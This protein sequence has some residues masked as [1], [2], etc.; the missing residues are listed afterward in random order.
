MEDGKLNVYYLKERIL[1]EILNGKRHFVIWGL[2]EIAMELLAEL[3]AAGIFKKYFSG[4]VDDNP[5][6][7]DVEIFGLKVLAPEEINNLAVDTLVIASDDNK[8]HILKTFSKIE[9]RIPSVILGGTNHFAFKDNLFEEVLSSCLI[10]SKAGGYP[11]MLIHIY[12]SLV[13]LIRN[14]IEGAVAEFGVLQGGTIVFIAKV[15]S[16]LGRKCRIFG[17]D[18]FDGFP[19]RKSVMDLYSDAKCVF[20]DF[21][22]VQNYCQPHGIELIKGDICETHRQIQNVPLMFSFFDTDNYSPTRAAL[23]LCYEQTSTGGILAFDHYYSP[24]WLYTIGEKIAIQEVLAN[25]NVLN[26][27]GTGIFIKHHS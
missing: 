27:H 14:N 23:E 8:E 3:Q 1:A 24:N 6:H 13:Y 17:F 19:E 16:K 22:S 11:N 20:Q 18:T 4:I 9:N 15:L 26:L 21:I 10:R 25:K 2:T 7:Q 5:Q 12:Q